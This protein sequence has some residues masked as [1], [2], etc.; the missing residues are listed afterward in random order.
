[1]NFR[2]ELHQL[3][4]QDS[5]LHHTKTNSRPRFMQTEI[6]S[7][8]SRVSTSTHIHIFVNVTLIHFNAVYIQ[9]KLNREIHPKLEDSE[10]NNA[11]MASE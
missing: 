8:T 10:R 11:N 1:M 2:V 3:V 7:K 5:Y 4:D 6:P 9:G